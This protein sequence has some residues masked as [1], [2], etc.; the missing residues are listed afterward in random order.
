[1]LRQLPRS[2]RWWS[3]ETVTSASVATAASRPRLS[4]IS[5]GDQ[6]RLGRRR[7]QADAGHLSNRILDEIR[8]P[9][10]LVLQHAAELSEERVGELV[11]R[12][13]P[14]SARQYTASGAPQGKTKAEIRTLVSRMTITPIGPRRSSAGRRS[15]PGYRGTGPT[16]PRSVGGTRN[17]WF[18]DRCGRP[19]ASRG[20]V[21]FDCALL[22]S[23][24]LGGVSPGLALRPSFSP[25]ARSPDQPGRAGV[26]RGSQAPRRFAPMP[27]GRLDLQR[28]GDADPERRFPSRGADRLQGSRLRWPS[29]GG[30]GQA[31]VAEAQRE[32]RGDPHP[33]S[34]SVTLR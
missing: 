34:T 26:R 30:G 32:L 25:P 29:D 31:E 20:R 27:R 10:E 3:P 9:R 4:G 14:S 12:T 11:R 13:R 24:P 15:R 17:G 6:H 28:G 21:R 2:S 1:M 18:L 7:D 22:L 33:L 23:N 8:I 16:L 5:S 19:R